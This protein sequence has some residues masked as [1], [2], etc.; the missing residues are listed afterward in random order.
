MD[1]L[2]GR[3]THPWSCR[4]YPC[5]SVTEKSWAYSQQLNY[6]RILA[7][8]FGC[9]NWLHVH[10]SYNLRHVFSQIRM[11]VKIFQH[12]SCEPDSPDSQLGTVAS[13]DLHSGHVY[14]ASHPCA[15][16]YDLE[17]QREVM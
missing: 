5:T 3:R 10:K 15:K 17:V 9:A 4:F 7:G 11:L 14:A 12:K 16:P 1:W 13:L 6:F 8:S 2:L